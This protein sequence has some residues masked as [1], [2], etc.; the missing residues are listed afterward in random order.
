MQL[1]ITKICKVK[2]L[3]KHVQ[4]DLHVQQVLELSVDLIFLT[5]ATIALVDKEIVLCVQQEL[6]HR[7]LV[8]TFQQ[9]A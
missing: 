8:L 4:L 7:K 5:Q 6:L 1:L 2:Q 3:A 9:I